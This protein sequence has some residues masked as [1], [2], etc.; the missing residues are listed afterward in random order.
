MPKFELLIG[1]QDRPS[2]GLSANASFQE[3]PRIFLPVHSL[4]TVPRRE[5]RSCPSRL[6]RERP[7]LP[8]FWRKGPCRMREVFAPR[9]GLSGL[10]QERPLAT[11]LAKA[12]SAFPRIDKL[13]A[14]A[15]CRWGSRPTGGRRIAMFGR[16]CRW[17]QGSNA[18]VVQGHWAVTGLLADGSLQNAINNAIKFFGCPWP[19]MDAPE[20]KH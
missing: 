7:L 16:L 8:S 2:Q 11:L 17:L 13:R 9:R 14:T 15:C 3:W 19:T 20:W 5:P 10:G 1:S 18:C 6:V 4:P 12:A